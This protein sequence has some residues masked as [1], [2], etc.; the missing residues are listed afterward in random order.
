M[1]EPCR[2]GLLLE[3]LHHLDQSILE[4]PVDWAHWPLHAHHQAAIWSLRAMVREGSLGCKKCV[5]CTT[6]GNRHLC[7]LG[8]D[9]ANRRK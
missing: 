1:V 9:H 8:E 7:E 4:T 5:C 2:F 3:S 6:F